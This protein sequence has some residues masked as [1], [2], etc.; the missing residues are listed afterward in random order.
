MIYNIEEIKL[1]DNLNIWKTTFDLQNIDKLLYE[2]E[3]IINKN[4]D[5][6]TDSYGIF[7]EKRMF[8]ENFIN[9][10]KQS[11]LIELM[12]YAANA[13]IYL[14]DK[15]FN[16]IYLEAWVNVVKSKNPVQVNYDKNNNLIFHNHVDLNDKFNNPYPNYT[17]VCYLQMPDNLSNND[18]VLYLK[19]K[20]DNIYAFLPK[21]G[22]IL[23]LKGDLDHVPNYAPKSTKDRI[24]LAGNIKITLTKNE[25][26]II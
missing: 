5:S 26:T 18:G 1:S 21:V 13:C 24:V 25:K 12:N 11:D 6:K 20:M 22:D 3:N 2:S 10:S 4:K 9:I 23:I 17:F 8:T 19:D 7:F 14:N 16:K 15:P